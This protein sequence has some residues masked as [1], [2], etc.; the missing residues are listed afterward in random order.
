MTDTSQY[1]DQDDN[2]PRMAQVPRKVIKQL[3]KE[4]AA[5]KE[6]QRK[7]AELERSN[8]F[9]KAGVQMD[10]PAADYFVRG[11]Q[12][13]QAPEVIKAEWE[14]IAGSVPSGEQQNPG[15]DAE[16]QAL[17]GGAELT[18]GQGMPTHDKLA[19]RDAKLKDLSPTDPHYGE[20]FDAIAREYG[21]VFGDMVS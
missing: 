5:G 3:E 4:A 16:L 2:Q 17:Q 19:E 20:K 6:A 15:I 10:H 13:D 14:R 7:L 18:A 1:L 9:L 12:G 8:A 11:Y 21:T